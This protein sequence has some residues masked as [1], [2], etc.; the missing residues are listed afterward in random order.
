MKINP[1]VKKEIKRH[2]LGL[3]ALNLKKRLIAED[4]LLKRAIFKADAPIRKAA[5]DAKRNK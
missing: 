1:G 2:N 4:I 3:P 5:R